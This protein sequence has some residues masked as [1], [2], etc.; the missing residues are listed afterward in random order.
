M[1][2]DEQKANAII[3][4]LRTAT[5]E[6]KLAAIEE[7]QRMQKEFFSDNKTESE[8]VFAALTHEA[9]YNIIRDELRVQ[10]K[11]ITVKEL[12]ETLNVES[13]DGTS[14]VKVK[15]SA[16][17]TSVISNS[18]KKARTKMTVA[19]MMADPAMIAAMK[20]ILNQ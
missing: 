10:L 20:G 17:S 4:R 14:V 2:L 5:I 15:K 13:T 12:A 1:P 18:D 6:E 9:F 16:K 19:Q 11:K 8:W 3:T 7:A